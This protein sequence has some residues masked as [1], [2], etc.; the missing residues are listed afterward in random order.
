LSRV[1]IVSYIVIVAYAVGYSGQFKL[2]R[3]VR[4]GS[5]IHRSLGRVNLVLHGCAI[6]IALT[7]PPLTDFKGIAILSYLSA[8]FVAASLAIYRWRPLSLYVIVFH[9]QGKR[10]NPKAEQTRTPWPY[11]WL[12]SAGYILMLIYIQTIFGRYW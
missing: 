2:P 5:P 7:L 12:C 3:I 1:L 8:L 9:P 11:V 4:P 10:G 6:A